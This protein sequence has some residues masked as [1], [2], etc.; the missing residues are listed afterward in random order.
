MVVVNVELNSIGVKDGQ[1]K[2]VIVNWHFDDFQANKTFWTDSNGLEMQERIL[3]YRFT[4][5]FETDQ[6]ISANYYPIDTAVALRDF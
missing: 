5:K 1:G 4:Y 3:N 6:N 2:D